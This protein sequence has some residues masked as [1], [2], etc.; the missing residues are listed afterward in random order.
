MQKPDHSTLPS[1]KTFLVMW[2][3]LKSKG[4]FSGGY[5]PLC[6]PRI[7]VSPGRH[8]FSEGLDPLASSLGPECIFF[9]TEGPIE[10]CPILL[11]APACY[12]LNG[13]LFYKSCEDNITLLSRLTLFL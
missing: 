5:S 4:I 11:V 1:T 12:G 6:V 3:V 8:V 9:S 2:S 7:R 13:D 10:T